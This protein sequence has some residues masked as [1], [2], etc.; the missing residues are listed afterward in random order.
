MDLCK[1]PGATNAIADEY[2]IVDSLTGVEYLSG[3][4]FLGPSDGVI[5]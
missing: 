2:G 1:V 5:K 3:E 4:G